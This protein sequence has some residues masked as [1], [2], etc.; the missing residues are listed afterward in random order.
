[1]K[2]IADQIK[3]LEATDPDTAQRLLKRYPAIVRARKMI[4]QEK[5]RLRT[6]NP[7]I[8]QALVFYR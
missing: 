3:M 5:K 8:D 1:M 7:A 4:A 2:Q 6:S